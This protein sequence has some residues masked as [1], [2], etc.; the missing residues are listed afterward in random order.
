MTYSPSQ[1]GKLDASWR[2]LRHCAGWEYNRFPDGPLA[3]LLMHVVNDPAGQLRGG[4]DRASRASARLV[5]RDGTVF[6]A[7]AT[8]P[9]IAMVEVL[10]MAGTAL[11]GQ[12]YDESA[13]GELDAALASAMRGVG[14]GDGWAKVSL[15][16]NATV[17]P[18][19]LLMPDQIGRL[20]LHALSRDQGES[21]LSECP[22]ALVKHWRQACC[23]NDPAVLAYGAALDAHAAA[24]RTTARNVHG[25][26]LDSLAVHNF[27]AAPPGKARNR[28]QAMQAL[29]WLLPMKTSHAGAENRENRHEVPRIRAAID[30][31]L[32]LYDA[33]AQAFGV[34]REVVRWLGRRTLPG[35]WIVDVG[36]LR[37]LLTLLSWLP[38]ERRPL[39]PAQFGVL[40]ALASALTAPLGFIGGAGEP[41]TLMRIAQCMRRWLVHET[42]AGLDDTAARADFP[43]WACD[44]V[45]AK[46]FLHALFDAAQSIDRL[47]EEQADA[48]VLGWC[49]GI[50]VARLLALSRAWHAAIAVETSASGPG[51]AGSR[52]PAVLAT[53]WQFENRTIVELTSR[54]Q[55]RVEGQRME[56]CVASYEAVCRS[57]NSLIVSLRGAAGVPMSTAELRLGDGMPR[58]TVAQHRAAWNAM[59]GPDCARALDA[60][61][62]HLNRADQ[63]QMLHRRREFQRRQNTQRS[64]A[65]GQ[66]QAGQSRF[67]TFAQAVARRL[68]T[69]PAL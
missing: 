24:Y 68:A 28:V 33:V 43:Q 16:H 3:H 62:V 31:G 65:H 52:W 20:A 46:D 1:P 54:A 29:P 36:R 60:L 18:R 19:P 38:P 50:R 40:N 63:H 12:H 9:R 64:G 25:I 14:V 35:N 4:M 17:L 67:N 51:D 45:D 34:P 48:W 2:S 39:T 11:A 42:Q 55:L 5:L 59:P 58:L 69:E 23:F 41:V 66:G 30:A 13:F 21:A 6:G 56:H 26:A 7:V 22:P 15:E 53:P 57:G 44:L 37:R 32:P 49:A 61:L 27:I 8:A 10:L 47:D